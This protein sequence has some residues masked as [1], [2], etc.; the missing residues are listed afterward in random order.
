MKTIAIVDKPHLPFIEHMKSYHPEIRLIVFK[1]KGTKFKYPEHIQ[2]QYV[3]DFSSKEAVYQDLRSIHE[4][5][6]I[7]VAT[8]SESGVLPLS[9]IGNFFHLPVPS[10]SAAEAAT[11]KSKMRRLFADKNP[12]ITPK[13][14]RV[15][16]W[17]DIE[18]FL[19][20]YPLP[21]VLKPAN[22]MKSLLVT[23]NSSLK[24]LERN[25]AR[26]MKLI[27]RLY[28][29]YNIS[30]DPEFIIEEFMEG[31]T[32]SVDIV[33]DA[34][35]EM[36]VL[37]VVDYVMAKDI[38]IN[39]NYVYVRK[40]PSSIEPMLQ[41]Q[42]ISVARRGVEALRFTNTAAHVEVMV[43]PEG[44][45]LIEIG[46]R[47]GGYRPLMYELCYGLEVQEMMFAIATGATITL[48]PVFKGFS[49]VYEF[50]PT[51]KGVLTEI[52]GLEELTKVPSY[53]SSLINL[54]PGSKAGLSKHG[55]KFCTNAVLFSSNKEQ[56]EKDCKVAEQVMIMIEN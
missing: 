27:E 56:L 52:R 2:K 54:K 10:I 18:R 13:F 38:G 25:F 11:D 44:P 33:V 17:E 8:I 45:K 46:A 39:D 23:K 35:G 22:L 43:T 9:W 19:K 1:G 14:A 16:R 7:G 12:T 53:F 5:E 15:K 37:P 30:Q 29:K 36:Q 28:Q 3:I 49:A 26:A 21:V 41:E 6:L 47:F 20:T 31:F 48:N 51:K 32:T 50:F 40:L 42:I 24:E 55:Y 34:R 4:P